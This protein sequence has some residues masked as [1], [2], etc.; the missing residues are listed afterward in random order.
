MDIAKLNPWNW[1][2]HEEKRERDQTVPIKRSEYLQTPPPPSDMMQLHRDIDRLFENAFRGFPSSTPSAL[3]DRITNDDVMRS[4]SAQLNI[5]GDERHYTVT[6]EA[7]G[8]EQKDLSIEL[9]ER[10]LII[11]GDKRHEEEEKD[12]HYYRMERRYGAFERIL[13]LPDDAD[14]EKISAAMKNG[15]LSVTIP[16]KELPASQIKRIEILDD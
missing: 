1:F 7:P 14:A 2:K 3:W 8:M 16:R 6:L 13:T 15:V 5:A 9:R 12:T 11:K 10:S 4:F